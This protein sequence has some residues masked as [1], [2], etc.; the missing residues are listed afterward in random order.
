MLEVEVPNKSCVFDL[1][2][3]KAVIL[4][5]SLHRMDGLSFIHLGC[6]LNLFPSSSRTEI[7]SSP[8]SYLRHLCSFLLSD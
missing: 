4:T 1:K 5:F 7:V 6:S 8:F 3:S 2:V